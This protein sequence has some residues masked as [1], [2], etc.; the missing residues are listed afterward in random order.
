VKEPDPGERASWLET[1]SGRLQRWSKASAKF[2]ET[3]TFVT[4]VCSKETAVVFS[5]LG[6][7]INTLA[8]EM[9]K[10]PLRYDEAR[11]ELFT[12]IFA[13]KKAMRVELEIDPKRQ[14]TGSSG[15]PSPA[16]P[17]PAKE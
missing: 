3:R 13:A 4:V 15:A 11:T 2:D 5:E 17:A 10:N 8:A 1:K 6:A 9:T 16:K 12:K 7:F 14:S